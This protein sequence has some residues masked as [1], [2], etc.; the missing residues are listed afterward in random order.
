MPK[1][2]LWK[3]YLQTTLIPAGVSILAI[4]IYVISD[5]PWP[6]FDKGHGFV[7]SGLEELAVE[8]ICIHAGFF[9]VAA[10]TLFL[11]L[12]KKIR[13]KPIFRFLSWFLVPVGYLIFVCFIDTDDDI[14][15]LCAVV[16]YLVALIVTFIRFRRR[17]KRVSY[18][19]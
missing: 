13:G 10:T 9:L 5:H 17:L 7:L 15:E 16:P 11:N 2:K 6:L 18:D 4:Y 1:L 14:F 3:Y 19:H 8:V 12:Y